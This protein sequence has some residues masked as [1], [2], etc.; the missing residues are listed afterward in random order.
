[1]SEK[2]NGH[3]R[4]VTFRLSDY[5]YEKLKEL[6]EKVSYS[7]E[8]GAMSKFIRQQIF[9]EKIS[10]EKVHDVYIDIRR[11]RS[12]ISHTLR[13][14]SEKGDQESENNLKELLLKNEDLLKE[15]S[16]KVGDIYGHN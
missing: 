8:K 10:S 4:I 3:N 13:T 12:E 9:S 16:I 2:K 6:V 15:I 7:S 14:Y 11:M 5:E 1:M